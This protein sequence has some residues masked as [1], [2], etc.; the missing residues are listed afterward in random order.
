[1]KFTEV[2]VDEYYVQFTDDTHTVIGLYFCCPQD[3]NAYSN[4]GT[5]FGN[6]SRY[7]SFY[8]SLPAFA[9]DGMPIPI[10]PTMTVDLGEKD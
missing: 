3:P 1:M 9:R 6:D 8:E 5:V 2:Y 4:L 7:I 10:Y